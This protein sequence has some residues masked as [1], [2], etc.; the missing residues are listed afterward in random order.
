METAAAWVKR[1]ENLDRHAAELVT[2]ADCYEFNNDW[3]GAAIASRM[4]DAAG[5]LRRAAEE[6]RSMAR[7]QE[8][9]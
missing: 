9:V 3:R 6:C 7:Q 4:R 8:N 5:Q 2:T 1:A